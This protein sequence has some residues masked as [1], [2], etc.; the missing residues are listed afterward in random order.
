M[1]TVEVLKKSLSPFFAAL[2][3]RAPFLS[4]TGEAK[5][6]GELSALLAVLSFGPALV[7]PQ[8]AVAP[9][10]LVE[11]RLVEIEHA[12]E[13][14]GQ[15][16]R[17]LDLLELR[18]GCPRRQG[19]YRSPRRRQV[20]VLLPEYRQAPE[21]QRGQLPEIRP[22]ACPASKHDRVHSPATFQ[23]P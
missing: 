1:L 5:P 9:V 3:L 18:R 2:A 21:R 19:K 13:T 7:R 12:T 8:V 16:E 15:L 22:A 4:F 11:G 17:R 10:D 6:H 14:F 20:V 23:T